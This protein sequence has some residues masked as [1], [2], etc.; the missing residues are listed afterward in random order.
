MKT[1]DLNWDMNINGID[2]LNK[3]LNAADVNK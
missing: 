3:C 1:I 2:K